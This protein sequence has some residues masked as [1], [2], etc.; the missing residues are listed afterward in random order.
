STTAPQGTMVHPYLLAG[1]ALVAGVTLAVA[2]TR[3]WNWPLAVGTAA[4]IAPVGFTYGRA[5]VLGLGIA[6]VCLAT[7]LFVDRRKFLP[8]VLALCIGVAVPTLIWNKGWVERTHQSVRAKNESNL[9][10]DRGWLIHE[11]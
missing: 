1:L 5:A 11:A 7:G 9:T 10:T 3:G 6:V 2:M 8:A 4:A